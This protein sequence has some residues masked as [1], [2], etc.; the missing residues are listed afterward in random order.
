[1]FESILLKTAIYYQT[2]A[3]KCCKFLR[4]RYLNKEQEDL[5]WNLVKILVDQETILAY[6]EAEQD[7][8]KHYKQKNK[9]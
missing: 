8:L 9:I 5:A 1:M 3:F 4:Q 7:Q 2:K 6:I